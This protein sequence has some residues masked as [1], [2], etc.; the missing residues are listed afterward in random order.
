[1]IVSE[2]LPETADI[3]TSSEEYAR[4]FSGEVGAWFLNVQEEGT[5]RMV[6][7]LPGA[8]ILDIGGGHGQITEA[9]L[10]NNF[11]VTVLGSDESCQARIR[12]FI[13]GV[14]CSFQ[15]GN[16]ID[17]PF[18][19]QNFDLVISY[20]LL[21]HVSRWRVFLGEMC[22]VAKNSVILDY[23]EVRSV[24][25]KAPIFF[26][27]K[28]NVEK[29]TR[30]FTCY[31]ERQLSEIFDRHGFNKSDRFAEFLLP[32][33]FHRKLNAPRVSAILEKVFR[34]SRLTDQFG[35]PVIIKYTRKGW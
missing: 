25:S 5:L 20:R 30:P 13:D 34:T 9:L 3:E 18:P 19:D 26:D 23:P 4:R 8:R 31:R 16:I 17:L 1:V 27:L 21:P 29:N 32:M 2:H 7:G 6:S 12:T 22:R 28:K 11:K 24:N 35:S 15:V 10:K 33:V 14:S